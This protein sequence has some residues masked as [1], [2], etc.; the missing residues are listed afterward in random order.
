MHEASIVLQVADAVA[1]AVAPERHAAITE[2]RCRVGALSGVQPVLLEGAFEVV[3][4]LTPFPQARL[5]C[6]AV[7]VQVHCGPCDTL[8][9]PL[10]SRY[11][12]PACGTPSDRIVAGLE[13]LVS[14]VVFAAPVAASAS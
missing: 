3:A 14:Q 13:L 11:A 6:E 8:F 7:A 5:A 1:A 2:I 9:A 12:C 4:P 10:H